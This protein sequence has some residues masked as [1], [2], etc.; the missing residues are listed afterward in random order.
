MW[1]SEQSKVPYL[2]LSFLCLDKE[3]EKNVRFFPKKDINLNE[4]FALFKRLDLI[5]GTDVNDII[6]NDD[7]SLGSI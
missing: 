6:V 1:I 5:L 2:N 4:A 7:D 3:T